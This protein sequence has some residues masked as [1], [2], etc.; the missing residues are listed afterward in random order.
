MRW[1]QCASIIIAYIIYTRQKLLLSPHS[2][3]SRREKWKKKNNNQHTT[4]FF[5]FSIQCVDINESQ[6]RDNHKKKCSFFLS[7]YKRMYAR[8]II[9]DKKK[10]SHVNISVHL[11]WMQYQFTS[12][13][14]EKKIGFLAKQRILSMDFNRIIVMLFQMIKLKLMRPFRSWFYFLLL[15]IFFSHCN[16]ML[17]C[18]IRIYHLCHY[19]NI[20]FIGLWND[21]ILLIV[22]ISL[23]LKLN[24]NAPFHIHNKLMK[25]AFI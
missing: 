5:S 13:Y 25:F 11:S 14:A 23:G 17:P 10:Y 2:T 1:A 19:Q 3:H 18:Y 15:F 24:L 12:I 16:S 21:S 9:I 20:H 6:W 4:F 7:I 22:F 8:M